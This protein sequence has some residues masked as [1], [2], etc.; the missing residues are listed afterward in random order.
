MFVNEGKPVAFNG[1][2]IVSGNA[3]AMAEWAVL[4]GLFLVIVGA[5]FPCVQVLL[6]LI[7]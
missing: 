5:T 3:E 6:F 4:S 7:F 2:G 1:K